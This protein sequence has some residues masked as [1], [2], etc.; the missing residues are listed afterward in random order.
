MVVVAVTVVVIVVSPSLVGRL[1]SE[2]VVVTVVRE[3]YDWSM[4]RP[5]CTQYWPAAQQVLP[6]G[7]SP[8]EN[9]HVGV[10]QVVMLTVTVMVDRGTKELYKLVTVSSMVSTKTVVK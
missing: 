8:S 1:G 3:L 7:V 6:Q 2:T 5:P 9:M 4:H 10:V